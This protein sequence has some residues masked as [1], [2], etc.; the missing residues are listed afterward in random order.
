MKAV[1]DQTDEEQNEVENMTDET[2]TQTIT[3]LI[4]TR[5]RP[6]LLR[7]A[8]MS[9][10][11]TVHNRVRVVVGWDDDREG[12]EYC[13]EYLWLHKLLFPVRHYYVR[14]VNTLFN[15]C[16]DNFKDFDYFVVCNDDDEF[17]LPGWG[18]S[19]IEALHRQFEDGMGVMEMFAPGT[20]GHW[21]SRK[22]FF[23]DNFKG[24]ILEPCY[25]QYWADGELMD[26]LRHMKAYCAVQHEQQA[27][28][29]HTKYG[30][31]D[32][33]A[34]EVRRAWWDLDAGLYHERLQEGI[35]PRDK[36]K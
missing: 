21:I 34:S 35:N 18:P 31:V 30:T 22:Q 24:R 3:I 14:A 17:R 12:Y 15:Y 33:L 5:R 10:V 16:V 29:S 32:A 36:D 8:M 26:T 19:A 1:Y 4:P 13:P 9:A 27:V 20:L 7:R 23:I 6:E 2:L 11:G 25:T 28:I